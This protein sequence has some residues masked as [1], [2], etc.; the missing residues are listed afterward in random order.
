MDILVS[1]VKDIM[2]SPVKTVSPETSITE[3]EN[4]FRKSG[5][6]GVIVYDNGDIKGVFSRRDLKKVR[7]HDLMQAPVKGYM[8]KNVIKIN[9]DD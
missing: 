9:A 8:S 3:V 2:S 1:Q 6:N 7:R 4:I 5:H